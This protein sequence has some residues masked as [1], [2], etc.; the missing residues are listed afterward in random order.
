[1]INSSSNIISPLPPF[2]FCLQKWSQTL[3]LRQVTMETQ[4]FHK[5][6]EFERYPPKYF[7]TA[8][9]ERKFSKKEFET[10][11]KPRKK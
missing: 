7:C 5:K 2:V 6:L 11:Q 10:F 8:R 3:L 1:M 4:S 9:Y